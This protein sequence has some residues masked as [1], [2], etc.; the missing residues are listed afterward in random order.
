VTEKRKAPAKA[1][2]TTGTE[3]RLFKNK[4]SQFLATGERLGFRSRGACKMRGA[5][6]EEKKKRTASCFQPDLTRFDREQNKKK[7]RNARIVVEYDVWSTK[8]QLPG[9]S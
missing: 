8:Y 7:R 2:N 5:E 3:N 9:T 6:G 4:T 1:T